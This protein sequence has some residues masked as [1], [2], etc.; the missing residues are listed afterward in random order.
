MSEAAKVIILIGPMGCGKT[1]VGLL[2]AETLGWP[3][4]DGDDFH[5]AANVEKMAAGIPLTDED[6]IPWLQILHRR[7]KDFLARGESGIVACSALRQSYREILGIDQKHIISVYLKG[8]FELLRERLNM[9]VHRYMND[10]LLT[11]Q[12]DTLEVPHSGITIEINKSPEE[13]VSTIIK[14]IS[15]VE[16]GQ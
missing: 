7:M 15:E 10:N 9:R 14:K 4:E 3:F 6:R 11:S 1:T 13:I 16:S 12:I 8:S 2:L 5:P